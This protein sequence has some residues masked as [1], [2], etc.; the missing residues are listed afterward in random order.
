MACWNRRSSRYANLPRS[1]Y[2]D[3]AT[4]ASCVLEFAATLPTLQRFLSLAGGYRP[5][6]E[7]GGVHFRC[8]KVRQR[9]PCHGG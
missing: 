7:S 1:N 5:Y 3:K 4:F 9:A 6:L 2:P 8:G